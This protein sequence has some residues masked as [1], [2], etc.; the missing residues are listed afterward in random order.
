MSWTH[1][2]QSYK[3]LQ[4]Q[5]MV[6]RMD[7]PLYQTQVAAQAHKFKAD[8]QPNSH[9]DLPPN[10]TVHQGYFDIP[11]SNTED[12]TRKIIQQLC[13]DEVLFG[14]GQ[15]PNGKPWMDPNGKSWTDPDGKSWTV[16]YIMQ[17]FQVE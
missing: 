16:E 5:G 17:C 10:K 12:L 6:P 9:P 13:R 4:S 2:K 11:E 3:S 1:A 15:D 7:T 14:K 8:T